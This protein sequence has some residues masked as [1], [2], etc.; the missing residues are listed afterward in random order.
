MTLEKQKREEDAKA[1]KAKVEEKA[2]TPPKKRRDDTDTATEVEDGDL[3]SS[4][5][6]DDGNRLE[7]SS[8]TTSD[9]ASERL[10]ELDDEK[11]HGKLILKIR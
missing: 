6:T 10:A 3:L 4:E 8:L 7:L 9:A 2:K 1:A 11:A 5:D